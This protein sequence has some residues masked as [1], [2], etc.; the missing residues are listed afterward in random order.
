LE[1]VE[2]LALISDSVIGQLQ[3]LMVAKLLWKFE[4]LWL[5]LPLLV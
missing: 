4:E 1:A 3:N 5:T 2:L